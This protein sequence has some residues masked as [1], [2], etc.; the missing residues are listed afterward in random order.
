MHNPWLQRSFPGAC[1][2]VGV[3][4]IHTYSDGGQ[5]KQQVLRPIIGSLAAV[6]SL[7]VGILYHSC[8][9]L[10]IHTALEADDSL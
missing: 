7:A 3:G 8:T 9:L 1:V 5:G 10:G 4:W 6:R 2:G